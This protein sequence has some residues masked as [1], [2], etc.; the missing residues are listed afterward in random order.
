MTT[1]RYE[2]ETFFGYWKALYQERAAK[3]KWL[4]RL[5]NSRWVG[6]G[7]RR[8]QREQCCHGIYREWEEEELLAIDICEQRTVSWNVIYGSYK[9]FDADGH[10]VTFY[11]YGPRK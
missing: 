4:R 7:V 2:L 9:F 5:K 11:G 8:K 10:K 3:K 6:T 1:L